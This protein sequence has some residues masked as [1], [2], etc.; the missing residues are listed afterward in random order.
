MN[1]LD[2]EIADLIERYKELK[3]EYCAM[4]EENLYAKYEITPEN[5]KSEEDQT[6]P[7]AFIT[8]KSMK[9]KD[10][11]INTFADAEA[12]EAEK[13]EAEKAEAEAAGNAEDAEPPSPDPVN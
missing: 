11:C 5:G 9:G 12:A 1:I 6:C 2:K 3:A 4:L 8:F 7:C 13:A 10:K